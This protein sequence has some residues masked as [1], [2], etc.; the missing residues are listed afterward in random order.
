MKK[1]KGKAVLG[2]YGLTLISVNDLFQEEIFKKELKRLERLGFKG[3]VVDVL[4][5]IKFKGK[6]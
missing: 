2:K 3:Q 5:E 4:V 1:I 6:V